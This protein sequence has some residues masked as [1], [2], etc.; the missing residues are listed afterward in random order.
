MKPNSSNHASGSLRMATLALWMATLA[1]TPVKTLAESSPAHPMPEAV[2]QSKVVTGHVV[3]DNGE[4][5]IGVTIKVGD[6][7]STIGAVT[8]IDGNFTINVPNGKQTLVLTYTGFK[9][10]TVKISGSNLSIT[11]EPD[12][13]GL[14]DVVVIG[15]GTMKRR[16]LTGSISSVNSE[17]IRLTPSS[18][19][20]ESMQG[21]ISG[22]D[23]VKS[24]GQAGAGL[25]MQLRGNRSISASGA[26]RHR[27]HRGP[28]G[29]LLHRRLWFRRLQ[30]CH[31]RHH[32]E[33]ERRKTI[34]QLQHIRGL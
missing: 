31:P 33:G 11:M 1:F 26:P 28:Q 22:L 21:R 16:D 34:R 17:T 25:D 32:Q 3:D 15:Y 9:Q 7:K 29:R 5:L 20:I 19:P 23:I 2:A 6:E 13:L 14:D 12:V 10:K 24:S 30:R 8:D 18:N 4:P 27:I